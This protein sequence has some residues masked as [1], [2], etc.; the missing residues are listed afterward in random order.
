MKHLK[1]YNES[2]DDNLYEETF[3]YAKECFLDFYD[4][5]EYDVYDEKLDNGFEIM[6]YFPNFNGYIVNGL[7]QGDISCFVNW[8]NK[9]REYYLDIEVAI[10]RFKDKYGDKFNVFLSEDRN[11]NLLYLRINFEFK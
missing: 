8:S 1:R 6:P 7:R 3:S 9:L 10:K 4:N 2:I 11:D 5:D